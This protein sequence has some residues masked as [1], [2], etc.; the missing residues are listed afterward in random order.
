[1]KILVVEDDELTARALEGILSH[2]NYAVEIAT[3]AQSAWELVEIFDYDLVLLDVVLPG[4]DGVALCRRMRSH[5]YAMP[6]MLVTA[7]DDSHDKA[8]GLDAGADDYVTKPFNSEELMARIRALLR[9]GTPEATPKLEWGKL[10]LDPE[11]C[12]VYYDDQLLP[13]TPK[14]YAL[15]ELLMRNPRRVFSCG[16]VIEHLWAYDDTPGEDA[17]RTH[18]KCVRQKMKKGGAP[19]T[20]IETVYGIGYRLRPLKKQGVDAVIEV[21]QQTRSAIANIWQQFQPRIEGQLVQIELAIAALSQRQLSA[22]LHQTAKRNCHSLKGALGMFGLPQ[23]SVIAGDL[24]RQWASL[25]LPELESLD[26]EFCA[27]LQQNL[28]L[29]RQEVAENLSENLSENSSE[30]LSDH[31]SD[32]ATPNSPSELKT[33]QPLLLIVDAEISQLKGLKLEADRW[34]LRISHVTSLAM[35]RQQ[36]RQEQVQA[37]DLMLPDAMLPDAMLPNAILFDPAIAHSEHMALKFLQE[38]TTAQPLLP[39]FVWTTHRSLEQRLAI[40][41]HGGR[42]FLD[43]STDPSQVMRAVS[44]ALRALE[45]TEGRVLVVDDD[46]IILLALRQLLEPWGLHVETL[47]DPRQFLETLERTDPDLLILDLKMPHITGI[48]LCQIVRNDERWSNL[49]ILCLTAQTDPDLVGRVFAAGA[50]DFLR[51]P[52]VG[53]ELVVRVVNR[54]ER[55]KLL[56]RL[57]NTDPLTG[58]LN[59]QKSSMELTQRL[60]ASQ[61]EHHPFCLALLD[62]NGFRFINRR[63]GHAVGDG[64]LRYLGQ[65][66]L[67]GLGPEDV[68][69]RWGG[70]EFVVGI[71][72]RDRETAITHLSQLLQHIEQQGMITTR[73][74]M[75]HPSCCF[76]VAPATATT[77]D[78]L[79]LY[80]AAEQALHDHKAQG[81][82]VPVTLG[83]PIALVNDVMQ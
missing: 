2:Q 26:A 6:I 59:R 42:R 55:T 36:L 49:S 35:A 17:V 22:E 80:Q 72:G 10:C 44:Q 48:E 57:L 68:V 60:E 79:S 77:L 76:G 13:L 43:K 53:P 12:E 66:L 75:I 83:E 7:K 18:I 30:N 54:L 33:E 4:M 8:L 3:S 23:G 50:D 45:P 51:K 73:G 14:E 28:V 39:V 38:L 81:Y 24:E 40:S 65:S 69:A 74:E 70:E 41:Q 64:V 15:L 52:I 1:M 27:K 58:L 67:R 78:L 56:Q 47:P 82:V 11:A 5:Q 34:N 46:P 9:R 62:V 71:V 16:M 25:K 19:N 61:R 20:L 63:Y 37:K 29:L 21:E 31:A 32:W